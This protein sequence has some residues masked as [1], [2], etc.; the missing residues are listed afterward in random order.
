MPQF[1]VLI[2]CETYGDESLPKIE[3]AAADVAAIGEALA[4][5]GFAPTDQTIL[6]DAKASK[7]VVESRLRKVLRAATADDTVY[8]YFVGHAFALDGASY[9]ACGDTTVDDLADTSLALDSLATE[10]QRSAAGKL[11]LFLDASSASLVAAE[12]LA[13]RI[14]DWDD[15]PLRA[16]FDG[17]PSRACFLSCTPGEPSRPAGAKKHGAWAFHLLEAL[18]GEAPTAAEKG[19][20]VTCATLLKHLKAAVPRTLRTAFAD[21]RKQTPSLFG[22]G[23]GSLVVADVAS[24]AAPKSKKKAE[25]KSAGDTARVA[26]VRERIESV[27]KLAGFRKGTRLPD[28]VSAATQKMVAQWALEELQADLDKVH[29]E[30]R[31]AFKF[32]RL[33]LQVDGPIDGSGTIITPGFSYSCGVRLNPRDPSEVIWR[34]EVVDLADADQA[35]SKPFVA[36]FEETFDTVS[37]APSEPLDVAALIDRIEALEDPRVSLDY[38]RETTWC[39]I[40]IRG[41]AGEIKVAKTTFDL[42]QSKPTN[43][44]KLLEA[45]FAIQQMLAETGAGAERK[46]VKKIAAK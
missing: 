7:S 2:G 29:A 13:D 37:L 9:L 26:L 44:K 30:L 23:D 11:V 18:N 36:V 35:A 40:T 4:R 32:K 45:F 19:G 16:A 3:Y 46:P 1:A 41:I 20:A 14:A 27:K 21:K 38:D 10:I 6:V 24:L 28:V 22:G 8:L 12:E 34:R 43:P 5:H 33:D 25:K 15:A 17:K 39:K 31:D 42:V